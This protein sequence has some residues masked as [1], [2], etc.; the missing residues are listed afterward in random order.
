[1]RN[2]DENTYDTNNKNDINKSEV[3]MRIKAAT[4]F[5]CWSVQ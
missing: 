4:R 5:V 3:A 2:K 1:M